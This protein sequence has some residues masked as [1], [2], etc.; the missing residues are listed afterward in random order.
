MAGRG[1]PIGLPKTGGRQ[2][3][4][5]DKRDAATAYVLKQFDY[6]P[7]EQLIKMHEKLERFDALCAEGGTY[8]YGKGCEMLD[9][10]D[11]QNDIN[12]ILMPYIRS[13]KPQEV[14][15]HNINTDE[16]DVTKAREAI[17][18]AMTRLKSSDV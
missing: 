12:K 8:L 2:K 7:M 14:V 1:R 18:K 15:Q 17:L 16:P 13:R 9:I 6:D 4:T 5:L 11:R 10:V 3:G